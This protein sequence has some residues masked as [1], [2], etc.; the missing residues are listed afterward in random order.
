MKEVVPGAAENI[1]SALR[2]IY[3]EATELGQGSTKRFNDDSKNPDFISL[4]P[5]LVPLIG[6]TERR[7]GDTISND[8][9]ERKSENSTSSMT[10]TTGT[11][12]LRT[13]PG[14]QP[15]SIKTSDS[16]QKENQGEHAPIEDRPSSDLAQK[17]IY[18]CFRYLRYGLKV[19]PLQVNNIESDASFFRALRNLY[20]AERSYLRRFFELRD[21][22]RIRYV[23]VS[24]YI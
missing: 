22:K 18:S 24:P 19:V 3:Q 16:T 13:A 2:S 7:L 4:K 11:S 6:N 12:T 9:Q 10:R 21:V 14:Q 15:L 20:F 17:Y 1:Q 5:P 8:G 23:H